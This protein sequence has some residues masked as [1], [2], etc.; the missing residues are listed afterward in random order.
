MSRLTKTQK[1][2]LYQTV[3]FVHMPHEELIALSN[4]AKYDIAKV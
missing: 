3:R 4:N 2:E 1:Q